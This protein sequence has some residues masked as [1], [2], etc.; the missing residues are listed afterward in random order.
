MT[1]PWSRI[2]YL[3][4]NDKPERSKARDWVF[5]KNVRTSGDSCANFPG[6]CI[7]ETLETIWELTWNLHLQSFHDVHTL[8][9]RGSIYV[10]SNNP[11]IRMTN[12]FNDY[13]IR[14]LTQGM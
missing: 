4:L 10:L 12:T 9:V 2:H 1:A 14:P 5:T 13:V 3:I 7:L 6:K 8:D 11:G